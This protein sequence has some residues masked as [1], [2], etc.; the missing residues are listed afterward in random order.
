MR[1]RKESEK[2]DYRLSWRTL[3]AGLEET[4]KRIFDGME[5]KFRIFDRIHKTTWIAGTD[6]HD[7]F[8]IWE[9]NQV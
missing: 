5:M 9:D 4:M 1:Q 2:A 7:T 8:H 3:R 6:Q